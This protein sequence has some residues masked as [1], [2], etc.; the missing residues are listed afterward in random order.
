MPEPR[1][2][3]R[4]LDPLPPV[5]VREF[6]P[7]AQVIE[8]TCIACDRCPPLCFFDAIVME[9]RQGHQHGRTAV[10]VTNNCTGCGLCF[11]ACPVDT[12]VWVPDTR[13]QSAKTRERGVIVIDLT[14]PISSSIP[15]YF[16]WHP[17]TV[18]EETAH[19][20]ENL[21]QVHRVSMGTHT[22]THIDAPSHIFA[23]AL[24]LDQYDPHL[25][26]SEA[27]VLDFT[28][29]MAGQHID[30]AEL[31]AK[32][33]RQGMSVIIKTGWSQFFGQTDYYRT[34]PPLTNAAAGYLVESG[35][36]LVAADTP[37]TLDVHRILLQHNIP[38]VTNINNTDRL[39][40][41]FVRLFAAPLLIAGG[42]GA[43][44]RVFAL[45]ES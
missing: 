43:P 31:R 5:F 3:Y 18:I 41:G 20:E 26:I 24:T 42:D 44:A 27:Q 11:E 15:V 13:A 34:Y 25:W 35:V 17:P 21:C 22:G 12:I 28:P 39:T 4:G 10:V 30:V 36:P 2:K 38:L 33:I 9:E 1:G 29:R 6:P 32:K 8:E 45:L 7:V 19:Y 23:G 40:E 16:P 37:Y 14:H